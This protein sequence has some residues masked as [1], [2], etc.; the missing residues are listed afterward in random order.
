[1]ADQD[2]GGAIYRNLCEMWRSV[3]LHAADNDS[4]EVEDR[5]DMLLVKSQF[6]H[7][8]PHMV[9]DPRVPAG[10]EHAWTRGIIQEWAGQPVSVM[11]EIPPGMESG[12]LAASL[13]EE[14][15]VRGM[16]P[17]IGM[18]LAAKPSFESRA[19]GS[20]ALALEGDDLDEAREVLGSVFGLPSEVFAFYTPVGVVHT[21]LL[22]EFG[23]AVAAACLCPFA[24][25]A[26]VYSV[27]VLPSARGK[28][29]ARRLVLYLLSQAAE[30]GLTTAVLSCERQIAPLYRSLGFSISCEL[31]TYW[32]ESLW[33]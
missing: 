8:V 14:G 10:G 21:F 26:G 15:F 13:R 30:M 28:G 17:S 5:D 16:R 22:R 32:M 12:P 27:G 4:F 19:D 1:M 20:I 3:G 18:V 23:I 33:R 2:Y 11:V 6:A 31:T 7:R 29:Y 24:G 9:L 25:V